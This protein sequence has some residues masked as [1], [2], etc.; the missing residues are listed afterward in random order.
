[1]RTLKSRVGFS[2]LYEWRVTRMK[3]YRN[4]LVRRALLPAVSMTILSLLSSQSL[5]AADNTGDS[6]GIS[7]VLLLSVDGLHEED[8]ARYVQLNPDSA[9]AELTQLGITYTKA[10]GSK[11]SNSF[12]G[13]LSMVTGGS[14]RT[15]DVYYDDNYDRKMFPPGSDCT[16]PAGPR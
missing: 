11:P 2:S 1:M 7:H 15:T 6:G 14:P 8:L 10:S 13:L 4:E 12:P 16:G 3:R 5:A 9:L